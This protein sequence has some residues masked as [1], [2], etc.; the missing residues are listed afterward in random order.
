MAEINIEKMAQNVAEKAIAIVREDYIHKSDYEARLRADLKAIL[1][2]IQLEIEEEKWALSNFDDTTND[3]V[4]DLEDVD[5]IIQ[6]K[7]DSL[8]G[9]TNNDSKRIKRSTFEE[10]I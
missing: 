1:T 8:K 2:E 10:R 4:V 9:E 7:I 3:Y 6:Q 5:R